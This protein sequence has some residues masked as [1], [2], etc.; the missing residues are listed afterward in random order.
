MNEQ[1]FGTL[2]A[3]GAVKRP[4]DDLL[5]RIDTLGWRHS[6]PPK[7]NPGEHPDAFFHETESWMFSDGFPLCFLRWK[8]MEDRRM[9]I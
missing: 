1:V 9:Q 6:G 8:G 5:M 2:S 3:A 7:A 4:S